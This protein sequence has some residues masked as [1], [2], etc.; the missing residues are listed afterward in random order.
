MN[1]YSIRIDPRNPG[2]FLAC[3]GL[4]EIASRIAP[5]TTAH[6]EKRGLVFHLNTPATLPVVLSLRDAGPEDS[7]VPKA[8]EQLSLAHPGHGEP[9]LINWWLSTRCKDGELEK[10]PFKTWGG[11]QTPRSMLTELLGLTDTAVPVENLFQHERYTTTRFGVDARTAWE[12]LDVGYS[13]NEIGQ[14]SV[15]FPLVEVLAVIGMQGFRPVGRRS[16]L[17]YAAWAQPLGIPAARA[18]AA[19]PWPG[20]PVTRFEFQMATR[21]QSYQTF[22]RAK[23]ITNE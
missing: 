4:L 16:A 7:R 2:Q 5:G 6:F 17:R 3:C 22:T 14:S 10:S 21:G 18:A 11:Q 19:A 9:L 12:P 13:P 1:T 8:L 23:E 20:L 15:T